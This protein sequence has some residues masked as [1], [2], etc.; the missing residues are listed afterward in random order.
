MG[1][2]QAVILAAGEGQRMRSAL[3]KVLHP[4]C[5]R[6]LL[7]YILDS[8]A[9]VAGDPVIVIGRGANLVR[10]TIGAKW[11]YA[12]QEKQLGTGHALMQAL[13]HLP[14][15]GRLLVLCG[16]TPLLEQD[17]LEQLLREHGGNAAT[18]MTAVPPDPTGYGRVIRD[19][20]GPVLR[21]VEEGDASIAEKK[22]GEINSGTYCFDLKLLRKYL[23]LL[24]P[25]NVQQEYYLTDVLL[26][27]REQGHR[28]GACLMEKWSVA[29]GINDRCQLAEAAAIMRGRINRSLMKRGVTMIDPLSTY[30][31]Y[32][33]RVEADTVLLPQTL[34]EGKSS[35][36]YG[37]RIGPEVHIM[38]A[39][40]GDEV[41]IRQSVV[42]ESILESGTAVGPFANIRPGC[43]I[44]PQVKIG[45][46]VE[47]KNSTIGAESKLPH[48]SYAGDVDI[49]SG[50]NL[51]AGVIVANFDGRMKYRSLIRKGA[52]IGCNSNLISP[53]EIGEGAFVAAGSTVT[54]DVPAG[55]LAIT[56]TEQKNCVGLGKRMLGKSPRQEKKESEEKK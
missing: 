6:P 5:G 29:L 51:G 48:H 43:R 27:M 14:E 18:V 45:D 38:N 22:V 23:P 10:E 34:I 13:P 41:V 32:D 55:A 46:F 15:E 25:E 3:P 17:D 35:I 50:V 8:A 39:Q 24:S 20:G 37:C 30:I 49:E 53:L 36:G 28:I 56:R 52:F 16:D 21:I 33:V 42:A 31:D 40:I 12:V 7:R 11:S 26:L 19:P 44:G 47:V 9:A 54:G 4:L 1:E 2:L